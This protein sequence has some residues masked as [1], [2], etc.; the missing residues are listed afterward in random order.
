MDRFAVPPAEARALD[1]TVNHICSPG[2]TWTGAQRRA[3]AA[4]T[5][6][7][8]AGGMAPA[9]DVVGEIVARLALDAQSV[10]P[11][12]IASVSERGVGPIDLVELLGVVSRMMAIDT[13][14][15]ALGVDPWPLPEEP[16][17]PCGATEPT[18]EVDPAATC[19]GGWLP[20]VGPAWPPN[21]LSAVP[22]ESRAMHHL[23][24]ALYLAAGQMG[25]LDVQ[26]GL[27]RTQMEL[28]AARTSLLNECFF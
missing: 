26:R 21:A 22:G 15:F 5:R 3:V 13:F 8:A 20:T 6:R 2:A 4:L 12:W 19:D 27:H 7:V 9:D 1:D 18:G 16:G 11:A 14:C 10:R 24:S 23:H 25:D 28:V 17:D